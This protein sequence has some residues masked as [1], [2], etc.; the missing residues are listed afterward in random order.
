MDRFVMI[1]SQ[2][3]LFDMPDDIAYLN[4]A[5]MSPLMKPVIDAGVAGMSRKAQPW[6][7]TPQDFFS[8]SE[9]ARGLFARLIGA[10]A[11][12]IAIVPS[13][14]YGI[15]S[16]AANVPVAKG[17][18]I[19]VLAEQFPSNVYSWRELGRQHRCHPAYPEQG[20]GR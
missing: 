8:D 12:D 20:A 19:L 4:C 9:A 11:G 6:T 18:E 16:A 3:H 1:A 13:A 10:D 5:Y 2:R 15:A 17:Q 14:S 7:I